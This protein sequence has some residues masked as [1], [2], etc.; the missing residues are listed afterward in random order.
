MA[1]LL[2]F[3]RGLLANPELLNH[4]VQ[5]HCDS[6]EELSIAIPV[7]YQRRSGFSTC[8][9]EELAL[10]LLNELQK[11]PVD[12]PKPKL[13]V[14][15]DGL[16][17]VHWGDDID[18]LRSMAAEGRVEAHHQIGR[19]FGYREDRILEMYPL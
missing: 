13:R 19:A 16:Y 14:A 4:A 3:Y 18:H 12:F 6:T 10:D 15:S 8:A 1:E 7:G 17:E 2:A 9:T 5:F 11:R